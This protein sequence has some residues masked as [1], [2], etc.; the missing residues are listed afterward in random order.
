MMK[1]ILKNQFSKLFS[2]IDESYELFLPIEMDGKVNFNLWQQGETVKVE[3]LK[4]S[5]SPKGFIFPQSET[6]LNFKRDGKKLK[7]DNVGGKKEDYVIFGVRHCDAKS[8]QLL[9]NVFLEAPVDKLYE[10]RREKGTIVTMAC[11]DPEETCFCTSFGIE[12]QKASQEVDVTTWDL[13]DSIL[14]Q[15]QTK[16]GEDLTEKLNDVLEDATVQDKNEL[17]SL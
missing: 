15:P 8:F 10:E 1:K 5:I 16:K 9:D 3:K 7:L 17:N 6:Y 11:F 14:W 12:P 2:M 4:T 13:G